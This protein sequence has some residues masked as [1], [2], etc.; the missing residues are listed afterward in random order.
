MFERV[1]RL[2]DA[3]ATLMSCT[4]NFASRTFSLC[5][6]A[7]CST[8]LEA[9]T[10]MRWDN[11]TVQIL[12]RWSFKSQRSSQKYSTIVGIERQRCE[13]Q[14]R[15][16]SATVSGRL[17]CRRRPD[18]SIRTQWRRLRS[19]RSD[20]PVWP[21]LGR[22][23]MVRSSVRDCMVLFERSS[24]TSLLTC[25]GRADD[26]TVWTPCYDSLSTL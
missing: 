12:R 14:R 20:K 11:S 2:T 22:V 13:Q 10:R 24:R 17:H 16:H 5:T 26:R 19:A 1:K 3:D 7:A 18:L 4:R 8:T 23:Y 21:T 6:A 9:C 15:V 25:V